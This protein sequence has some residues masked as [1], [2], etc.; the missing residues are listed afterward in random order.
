MH[1]SDALVSTIRDCSAAGCTSSP[2]DVG[3]CLAEAGSVDT[4]LECTAFEALC[5]T[6]R[7]PNACT[8][9]S[10]ADCLACLCEADCVSA[11]EACARTAL[12]VCDDAFGREASDEEHQLVALDRSAQIVDRVPLA[13][14]RSIRRRASRNDDLEATP[15]SATPF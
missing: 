2:C 10:N 15:R 9:S 5:A 4:C 14:H 12:G 13:R 6:Q 8:R 11:F 3:R 1:R 7:C